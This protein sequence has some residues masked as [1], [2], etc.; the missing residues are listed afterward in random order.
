MESVEKIGRTVEEAVEEALKILGASAEDAEVT[1]IDAGSKGLLGFGSRPARVQVK[2]KQGPA[3]AAQGF[4]REVALAMGL[5]V[6]LETTQKDKHLYINMVGDNMGVLIGKR[7]QTLD[8]LQYLTNL[9]VNKCKVPETSVILDTENYRKRRRETLEALA[10]S[11]A[12]K[13]KLTKKNVVLEPMSRYER[14]II[15]TVLQHDRYVKTYS[16]GNEP[17]RNVIIAPK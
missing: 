13:V 14:H 1:V 5:T 7:G 4:L 15:H 3:E 11:L 10:L 8:S 2:L 16:E 9:V 6:K 12:K 17:Y